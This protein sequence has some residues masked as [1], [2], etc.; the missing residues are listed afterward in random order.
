M[1][2]QA[3]LGQTLAQS[4]AS[5]ASSSIAFQATYSAVG[6][7]AAGREGEGAAL[8]GAVPGNRSAISRIPVANTYFDKKALVAADP[9]TPHYPPEVLVLTASG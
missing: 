4:K 9:P 6:R 2:P 5:F 1:G 7:G 3:R 8:A